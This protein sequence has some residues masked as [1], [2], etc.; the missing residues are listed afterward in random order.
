MPSCYRE[1]NRSGEAKGTLHGA[2]RAAAPNFVGKRGQRW[3]SSSKFC[4][5]GGGELRRTS[6]QSHRGWGTV[7]LPLAAL[8]RQQHALSSEE[9]LMLRAGGKPSPSAM[10]RRGLCSWP[11]RGPASPQLAPRATHAAA[12]SRQKARSCSLASPA[13]LPGA[14]SLP[15]LEQHGHISELA[16]FPNNAGQASE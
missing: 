3:V 15:L 8:G 7:F 11:L 9:L 4:I 1:E 14:T 5:E 6:H 16:S 13:P 10:G 2:G 12:G